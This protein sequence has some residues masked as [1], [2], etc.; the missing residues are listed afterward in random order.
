MAPV[1][2][3]RWVDVSGGPAQ[4]APTYDATNWI[5]CDTFFNFD[6]GCNGAWLKEMEDKS[7]AAGHPS[8]LTFGV[9]IAGSERM[10]YVPG[11]HDRLHPYGSLGC[12]FTTFRRST[13]LALRVHRSSS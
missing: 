5:G 2:S 4:G 7:A 1:P 13:S 11:A 12:W 8:G 6:L 3:S 10:I 9:E